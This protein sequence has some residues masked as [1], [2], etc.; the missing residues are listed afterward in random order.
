MAH[1]GTPERTPHAFIVVH[2]ES[3]FCGTFESGSPEHALLDAILKPATRSRLA[4]IEGQSGL[5]MKVE[6]TPHGVR[7]LFVFHIAY[8]A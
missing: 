7:V 6:F 2:P 8:V 4:G 1:H 3:E 5:D